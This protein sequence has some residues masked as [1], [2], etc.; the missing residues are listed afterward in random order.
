MGLVS[1]AGYALGMHA[2]EGD[3]AAPESRASE[4]V[5]RRIRSRVPYLSARVAHLMCLA[6]LG[7][8]GPD[9]EAALH[10]LAAAYRAL[11]VFLRLTR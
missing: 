8:R 11:G 2:V 10:Q 7:S 4:H 5:R 1:P 3:G 6:A 9:P